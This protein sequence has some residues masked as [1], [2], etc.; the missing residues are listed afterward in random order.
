MDLP[1]GIGDR[2][3]AKQTI[4]PALLGEVRLSAQEAI[5]FDA[6]ID[7]DVGNVN[8]ERPKLARHALR[9][10]A[11]ASLGGGELR[12]AGLAAQARR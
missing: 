9:K 3:D 1:I 6:T 5:A 4:L 11:Q 7:Y 10:H 2:V 12:E 8:S